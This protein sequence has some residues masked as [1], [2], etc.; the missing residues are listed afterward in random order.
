[1]DE[2][3]DAAGLVDRFGAGSFDVVLS[4][5]MLEHV[6][7]WPTVIG[8]L[9]RVLRPGGI[10]LVTTRSIGF[11]YH[12]YP[13][14]YWRYEPDDIRAIFADLD[15]LEV[16]AD[17]DAPGVFMLARQ[18]DGPHEPN[19]GPALYSM[20]LGRR[21][22]RVTEFQVRVFNVRHRVGPR[23]ASVRRSTART[24]R[25]RVI[26]PTWGLNPTQ[27]QHGIKRISRRA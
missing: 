10:L 4:T 17:T 25:R 27:A 18:H 16:E 14:D 20:I 19:Q 8:N 9:K 26:L 12:G 2:E 13:F 23:V 5:E 21:V 24:V 22:V 1:M 11:P 6:R 15:V 7:D 3:V